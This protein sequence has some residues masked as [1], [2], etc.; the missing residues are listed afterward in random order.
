MIVDN[1]L[2]GKK[3]EAYL[4]LINTF[5]TIIYILLGM[6]MGIVTGYGIWG[7]I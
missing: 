3:D 7:I 6:A 2:T 5:E 1:N 4:K